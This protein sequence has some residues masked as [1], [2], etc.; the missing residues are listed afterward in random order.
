MPDDAITRTAR[1]VRY[2]GRGPV[3]SVDTAFHSPTNG[4]SYVTDCGRTVSVAGAAVL[5]TRPVTCRS[6]L[7]PGWR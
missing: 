4:I 2:L 1:Q 7:L 5:T 6:C 3:H